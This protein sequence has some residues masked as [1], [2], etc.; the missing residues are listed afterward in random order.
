MERL[1]DNSTLVE[2]SDED[3]GEIE[4][5]LGRFEVVGDRYHKH[6]MEMTNT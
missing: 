3:M 6:G 1:R 4:G 2:L 5:V